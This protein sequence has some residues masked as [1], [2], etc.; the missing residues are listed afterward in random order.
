MSW[1]DILC[2]CVAGGCIILAVIN[3]VII[4]HR[5][6]YDGAILINDNASEFPWQVHIDIPLDEI[7][8]RKELLLKV[9]PQDL[10]DLQRVR[11]KEYER[12][13]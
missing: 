12:E 3:L 6:T 13:V 4:D 11:E 9:I 2:V 10:E 5:K 7:K 1:Y 8:N